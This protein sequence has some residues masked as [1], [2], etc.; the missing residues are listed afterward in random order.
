MSSHS[1][2]SSNPFVGTDLFPEAA[3]II[4][5]IFLAVIGFFQWGSVLHSTV[6]RRYRTQGHAD[7]ESTHT[8][9]RP[10]TEWSLARLP[11]AAVNVFR[12]V[13]FRWTLEVGTYDLKVADIVLTLTYIAFLL[14]WTF[15]DGKS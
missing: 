1:P 4:L 3:W 5:S 8:S 2:P 12:V 14:F 15:M 10:R 6:I 13:A 9:S 7:E 11:L